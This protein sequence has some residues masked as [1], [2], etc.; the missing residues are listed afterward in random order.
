[1]ETTITLDNATFKV[2]FYEGDADPE[3]GAGYSSWEVKTQHL[4]DMLK[5]DMTDRY[6]DDSIDYEEEYDDD[7][8]THISSA[9]ALICFLAATSQADSATYEIDYHGDAY[10]FFHDMIHAEYD[11]GDG[12]AVWID[13]NSE[14]RALSEGA[15]LAAKHDIPISDILRELTRATPEFHDRFGFEF[16]A[17]AAFLENVELVIK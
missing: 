5:R 3:L 13:E 9:D 17:V 16:D 1:M 2:R 7:D 4:A 15:K 11:S 8:K 12:S 14:M 6:L 10:W